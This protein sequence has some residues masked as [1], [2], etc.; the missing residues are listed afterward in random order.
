[1]SIIESFLNAKSNYKDKYIEFEEEKQK[2]MERLR[3]DEYYR[4][5]CYREDEVSK[6]VS[7]LDLGSPI[8]VLEDDYISDIDLEIGYGDYKNNSIEIWNRNSPKEYSYAKVS[9]DKII[10]YKEYSDTYMNE[11]EGYD[12]ECVVKFEVYEVK[13]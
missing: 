10:V 7:T 12:V 9:L 1:M 4:D 3:L 6:Y 11:D 13:I 8:D 2:L 5:Y